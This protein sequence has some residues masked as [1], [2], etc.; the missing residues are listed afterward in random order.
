MELEERIQ[1]LNHFADCLNENADSLCL[2]VKQAAGITV[3]DSK[4]RDLKS[5]LYLIRQMVP[6]KLKKFDP[7]FDLQDATPF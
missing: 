3:K 6:D 5:C 4:N 2:K 7:A 1:C